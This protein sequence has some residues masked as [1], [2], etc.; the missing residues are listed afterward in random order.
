MEPQ[1]VMLR[2]SRCVASLS[3]V[4]QHASQVANDLVGNLGLISRSVCNV[5]C[6]M[7]KSSVPTSMTTINSHTWKRELQHR[8][9]IV[10]NTL[11]ISNKPQNP[12]IPS[13][14]QGTK[15][16]NE[17]PAQI[18]ALRGAM[19]TQR[20]LT[21]FALHNLGWRHIGGDSIIWAGATFG[22]TL[23]AQG[24]QRPCC[25]CSHS[26]SYFASVLAS[27]AGARPC[28]SSCCV[29]DAITFSASFSSPESLAAAL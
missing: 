1:R 7:A 10:R 13:T 19:Q 5:T 17:A 3:R 29:T 2:D 24:C 16:P 6:N 28:S 9:H 15:T 26:A 20:T 23:F 8:S 12:T 4:L 18:M 14:L 27:G 11:V 25:E 22:G 21:L